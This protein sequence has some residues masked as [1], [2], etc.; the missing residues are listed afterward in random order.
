MHTFQ[1]ITQ[2]AAGALS[3]PLYPA[4]RRTGSVPCAVY[5][6][7]PGESDGSLSRSRLEVRIFASSAQAAHEQL[8]ALR[9]VLVRDGD[10][11]VLMDE[12]G[13]IVICAVK[14]G[15]GAG[16]IDDSGEYFAKMGF[17]IRAR[18]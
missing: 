14:E 4:P 11:G 3:V 12:D 2:A 10:S 13:A 18:A 9:R 15:G 5:R 17:D 1:T 8:D 7:I 16:Y 6:Y